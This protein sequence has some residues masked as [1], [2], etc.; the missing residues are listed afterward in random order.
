MRRSVLNIL[1]VEDDPC[2]VE[3]TRYEL[4]HAGIACD[5]RQVDTEPDLIEALSSYQPDIVLCDFSLPGF[6]GTSALRIV[7]QTSPHIP[8]LFVSGT[9]GEE[10]AIKALKEGAYDYILKSNLARLPS[11]VERALEEARQNKIRHQ[12][13]LALQAERNLL[14]TIFD[15]TGALGLMLDKKGRIIRFNQAA[16]RTTGYTMLQ[17]KGKHFWEMF[18]CGDEIEA[19]HRDFQNWHL[20]EQPLQYQSHWLT[21]GGERREI[22]WL[23]TFLRDDNGDAL[24]FICSGI[25]ITQWRQAEDRV[26]RLSNYDVLTGLPN[27]SLLRDRLEQDI[28]RISREQASGC[29]AVILVG[30]P[31]AIALREGLGLRLSEDALIE[32]SRRLSALMQSEATL[33]RFDDST[34]AI[35]LPLAEQGQI[36]MRVQEIIEDL[37]Q[38]YQLENHAG[39]YLESKIGV[40]VYPNDGDNG[41]ALLQT[42]ELALHRAMDNTLERCQFY[43]PELNS[44]VS[45]RLQMVSQLRQ[46]IANNELILHYQPQVSLDSGMVVGV[47]A[48]IRWQHPERGLVPPLQFIPLAEE[49]GLIVPI[50]EW[51]LRTACAQAVQWCKMGLPPLVMAVNL[52][53][54]QFAHKDIDTLVRSALQDSGMDSRFLELELTESVSMESP[55]K[56]I[57]VMNSLKA[58]GVR[59][60]LDDFGTGYSNLNYL[61]RFPVDQLKI[62][63]SFVCDVATHIDGL[64]IAKAII[65]L[66]RSLHLEVL[67]EGVEDQVQFDIMKLQGCDKVQGYYFSK[68]LP[69]DA[70][71]RFLE[72]C[73]AVQR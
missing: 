41:D 28:G 24:H 1:I 13:E 4:V 64:A 12:M 2:D 67:A 27:R 71:T 34:F 29:I 32:A 15:T 26:H 69:V 20:Q 42:A 18:F 6:D 52:S 73:L 9:M 3:L 48:L 47:E 10:R 21:A 60:S 50:G 66:A 33:A 65:A 51:V 37:D 8:F 40:T 55:E 44:Q 30:V 59:L 35:V 36:A 61:R 53:A 63:R 45:H 57:G 19:N 14:S 70:C 5:V 58:M 49:T 31:D 11:A 56:S 39:V 62:D 23:T 16:E 68:P 38:P 25:D 17:V 7:Q 72:Q 22:L 43:T 46:A 54:K